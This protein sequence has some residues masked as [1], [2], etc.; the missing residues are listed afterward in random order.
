MA[1]LSATM[2]SICAFGMRR[3]SS[4]SATFSSTVRHGNR[5][6][7]WNTMAMRLVRSILRS[8]ALQC[9]TSIAPSPL[10]T[11]TLPRATLLRPLTAR[12]IVDLPEP[13][14]PMSTQI[15]L[16]SIERLM[17]AAPRTTPV[18]LRMSSRVAPLSIIASAS[19]C[20][21]PNTMSTLSKTTADMVTRFL[22]ARGCGRRDRARSPGARSTRP[23]RCPSE[24]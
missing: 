8:S 1:S 24:C 11:R 3:S 6:N 14:R 16:G 2:R 10:R 12:R 5:A 7:C 13:D 23:P 22:F 18:D 17:P 9:A 21:S 15:S 19:A 20:L 4:P